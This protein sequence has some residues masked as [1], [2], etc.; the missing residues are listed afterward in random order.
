MVAYPTRRH[1]NGVARGIAAPFLRADQLELPLTLPGHDRATDHP[2]GYEAALSDFYDESAAT[3]AAHLDAG[4]DVAVLCEGDPFFY[5]SYMYLHERLA[6]RYD[7]RGR[8]GRDLVQRRGRRGRDAAR[9]A[10]R[11]AHRAAGDAAARRARRAPAGGRRGRRDEARAHV[12]RRARGGRAGRASRERGVYVER[13]SA[14]E[15]ADRAARATSRAR[16]PYMSL[17]LVPTRRTAHGRGRE[18]GSAAAWRSSG[19]ARPGRSG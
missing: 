5:G 18:T 8:P 14:P 10:R 7:D 17:V 12:R 11:R 9:Q 16:C 2:G 4:R 6:A 19:S 15:R 3:L 1:G 13:A